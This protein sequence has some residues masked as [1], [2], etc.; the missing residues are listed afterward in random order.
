MNST[1]APYDLRR[2]L[3]VVLS[4]LWAIF[5]LYTGVFGSF[6]IFIQ[7]GVHL[8][9]GVPLVFLVYPSFRRKSLPLDLALGVLSIGVFGYV[10]ILNDEIVQRLVYVDP[11]PA[12]KIV[13]G[14]IGVLLI[15]EIA[16]RT[17]GLSFTIVALVF[18]FYIFVGKHIPGIMGH[19]GFGLK[20]GVEHLFFTSE[21]IFGI[22]VGVSSTYVYLFILFGVFLETTGAGK[23]FL[24]FVTSLVGHRIG[25][26][27]KVA[28]LSSAAMGTISGSAI[29]NVVTTGTFTIPLM[30]KVGFEPNYAAGVE[31]MASTG[32]QIMPPIMGVAAFIMAQF[33]G[34]PYFKIAWAAVIPAMLYY[35]CGFWQIHF[36]AQRKQIPTIPKA[37]LPNWRKVL[38]EGW[39]YIASLVV[40]IYFLA[41]GY[42]PT[43]AA[44]YGL[45]TCLVA[46]LLFGNRKNLTLNNILLTFEK[47]T[48]AVLIV[49]G[50]VAAAGII[51]GS[52]G[53]TGLGVNISHAVV[54]L[55]QQNQLVALLFT[56]IIA[57][58]LGL[59]MPT[60]A[61]YIICAAVLV[62][63]LINIGIPVLPAHFFALFYAS[64]STIT[65]PVALASYTAASIA[66]SDP[67]KTGLCGF[68]L[69]L[70]AY[71]V[72]F[73]FVYNQSLLGQGEVWR[74]V[75][76][77]ITAMA[78][79][80]ALAAAIEGWIWDRLSGVERLIIGLGNVG[81]R[82]G[83]KAAHG[84]GMRV[85]GYDPY[86]QPKDLDPGVELTPRWDQVFQEGDFVSLHLPLNPQTRELIR[87]KEF[88]TM[89]KTAFFINCARG[90]IAREPDLVE[91]LQRG[92][93]AGAGL[94]V[95]SITPPP[96]ENPLL[97]MDN[98]IVTPHYAAHTRE[99][100]VNMATQAAQGVIEVLTNQT[101]TWAVNQ[102][103]RS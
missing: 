7:R 78:G 27:A 36:H 32:G 34:I 6:N 23:F 20:I 87:L 86:V 63:S 29:A 103:S 39:F 35:N 97:A 47:T 95:Y 82:L 92:F 61:A 48:R 59:G 46:V 66:Q 1:P 19:R 16:R 5:Q 98:T 80:F 40:I 58:I 37:Q 21:G 69:A 102:V 85:I 62:P 26:P 15:L 100:I 51:I 8:A 79:T 55:S 71:L 56:C 50:A 9:F 17:V 88:K 60:S 68:K 72:P 2:I 99:S 67:W 25:G 49:I 89:K 57:T 18:F 28:L 64:L 13:W 90:P 33:S 54:Y 24:D 74:M 52:F 44:V 76:A 12:W 91:A 30:K 65:P 75:L 10:A 3:I 41:V 83:T 73:F 14:M 31:S 70:A 77:I 38:R 94:D 53:L 22:P 43:L 45:L 11:M 101:P 84:L 81:R 96:R 4:S 42:T 93:I